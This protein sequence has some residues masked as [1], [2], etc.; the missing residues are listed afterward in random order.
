MKKTILLRCLIGAPIGLAISTV[1]AII[2][3]L[4]VGDGAYYAVVPELVSDY[5]T[6][7]NAV[8]VQAI[9]SLLYG[10]A[11]SGASA[12][13]ETDWSL[14]RMTATHL[15]ICSVA[16]FPIAYAMRWMEHSLGGILKYVGIFVLIY[17]VIWIVLY[18]GIKRKIKAMNERVKEIK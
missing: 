13:W 5:G 8:L 6:E 1:I 11:F 7:I 2:I 4:I 9:F 15:L 10:A 3:S 18:Y 14:M 12:V 17:A 16:T